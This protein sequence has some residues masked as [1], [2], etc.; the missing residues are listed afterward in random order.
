M[1][2]LLP[3]SVM[4]HIPKTGGLWAREAIRRCGIPL[5]VHRQHDDRVPVEARGRFRFAFVREPAEWLR[6]FWAY[7]ERRGWR[8]Y[9]DSPVFAF[10][11]FRGDGGFAGFV[12]RYLERGAGGVNRLFARYTSGCQ[13]VGRT[14]TIRRDLAEALQ[15]AGERFDPQVLATF[16]AYNVSRELPEWPSGLREAVVAAG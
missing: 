8:D 3:Q 11:A 15:R 5:R 12:E 4:I 14:E 2:Y 7:H 6:S 10:Y 13:F 1:P 16:P 9:D